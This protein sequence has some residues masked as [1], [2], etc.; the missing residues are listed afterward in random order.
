VAEGP[1][2]GTRPPRLGG[3]IVGA[4]GTVL[5]WAFPLVMANAAWVAVVALFGLL[6]LGVP[7]AWLLVPLLALPTASLTRL[8][9][10]AVRL[11]VPSLRIAGEELVRLPIRKIALAALQLL[12]VA[13][14]LTN[15]RLAGDIG[16]LPG[17]LSAAVAA[18]AMVGASVLAVALWPIVCDPVREAPVRAQLR[19]ALAVV[20][21]RPLQLITLAVIAGLAALVC[22]QL[23][24]PA[25]ILPSLVLLA[26]AGYVVPAADELLPPSR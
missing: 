26:I 7:A 18:Y 24:V 23:I 12:L 14:G 9:V 10:T 8:A 3:A 11:G 19:L 6:A 15:V 2:L 16:G 22:L 21:R 25:L 13:I 1:P 4:F 17:V 20:V 5:E